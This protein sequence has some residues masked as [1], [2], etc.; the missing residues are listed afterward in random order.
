MLRIL[1]YA[2]VVVGCLGFTGVVSAQEVIHAMTG[3]IRS[4]K[5]AQKT[6]TLLRDTGSIIPF[7]DVTDG[8]AGV[9]YDK[10]VVTDATAAQAFDKTG[11][12]V[13]VFYYGL[14]DNPT[15]VAVQ[16]LGR[17]PFT[18]TVGTVASFNEKDRLIAVK[19]DSGSLHKFKINASTVAESDI[20]VVEG[21]KI[22]ADKG[23]HIR[24]VG[25][26][27]DDSPTALFV[28]VM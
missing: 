11:A 27:S 17:G 7:K 8:K 25:E 6:F 15:A 10:R 24:V 1:T 9:A 3:T 18:A 12:Y 28:N 20:G 22:R 13:I 23:D 21:L 16:A 5:T 4:I 2:C 14:I 26:V 19:D